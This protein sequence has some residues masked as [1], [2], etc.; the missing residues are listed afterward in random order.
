M[1]GEQ[2][3][4]RSR[5]LRN[6]CLQRIADL[7]ILSLTRVKQPEA[8]TPDALF[9]RFT[10]HITP[11][12]A[13]APNDEKQLTA[14]T[15]IKELADRNQADINVWTDGSLIT[16]PTETYQELHVGERVS[17]IWDDGWYCTAV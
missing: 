9:Q 1:H 5:S 15:F 7:G 2:R 6:E 10:T 8:P 4:K 13:E 16:T 12:S 14:R 3:L 17:V 11:V